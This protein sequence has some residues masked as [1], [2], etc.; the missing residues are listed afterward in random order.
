MNAITCQ[1]NY[2]FV[3]CHFLPK[4]LSVCKRG[5]FVVAGIF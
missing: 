1:N 3:Y 4:S 5:F 2:K